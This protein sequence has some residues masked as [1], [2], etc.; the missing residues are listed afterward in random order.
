MAEI[1]P[2]R[3]VLVTDFGEYEVPQSVADKIATYPKVR[4]INPFADD[5]VEPYEITD[6][7]YPPLARY[8]RRVSKHMECK[9]LTC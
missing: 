7:N 6:M 3:S 5:D 1:V 2:M 4:F 9:W 8:Y